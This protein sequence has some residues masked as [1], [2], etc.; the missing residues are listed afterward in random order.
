M[1]FHAST[2][3]GHHGRVTR[4][5]D[6]PETEFI[7]KIGISVMTVRDLTSDRKACHGSSLKKASVNLYVHIDL[8]VLDSG[9][10]PWA[11]CLTPDGL[12]T[13]ALMALLQDLKAKF[14]LVGMSIVELRPAEDMDIG[15][16][17][18]LVDSGKEL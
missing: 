16:L 15:P 12:D 13:D 5:L 10:C 2:V 14:D 7:E 1:L 11:L 17:R 18:D 4:D 9:K 3:A 6:P 8:D